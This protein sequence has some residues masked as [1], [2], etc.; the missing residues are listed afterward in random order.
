[1]EKAGLSIAE[2]DAEE[3]NDKLRRYER[4]TKGTISEDDMLATRLNQKRRHAE[5]DAAKARITG[6]TQELNQIAF[7]ILAIQSQIKEAEIS[8]QKAEL[9]HARTEIKAPVDGRVLALKGAPGQKIM[10]GMDDL[11]SSTIAIIYEPAHLQVRVDVPLADAAGLS[12][13]QRAKIRSNL[14]PD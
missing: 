13:G 6:I 4:L 7:E 11:D 8:L 5:V 2:A 10:L 1:M 14:L 9:A 3:A 12:V